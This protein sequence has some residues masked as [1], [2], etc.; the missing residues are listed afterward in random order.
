[1]EDTFQT[2]KE[3]LCTA[4]ILAYLQSIER[5]VVVTDPSN[6]SIEGVLTQTQ[7]GQEGTIA[8]YSKTLNKAKRNYCVTRRKLLAIVRTLEHFHK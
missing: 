1:V 5:F 7:E 2:L 6:N 3:T 4:R 8:Y